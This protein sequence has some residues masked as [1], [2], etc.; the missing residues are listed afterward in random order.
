MHRYVNAEKYET[1]NA[2]ETKKE[3]QQ[4][5]PPFRLYVAFERILK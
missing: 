3:G 4:R 2:K 1:Q 5:Q